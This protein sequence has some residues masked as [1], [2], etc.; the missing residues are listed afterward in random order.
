VRSVE[1][2][3]SR[4]AMDVESF[5]IKQA[6]LFVGKGYIHDLADI[7]HLPWD[8]IRTL[9]GYGEKRVENLLAGIEGSKQQPVH[10]LLTALGI[11][12]V[13]SVVAELLT[14][15]Y[16]NLFELMDASQEDLNAIEGV[17]PRIAESVHEWFQLGPNRE[18]IA[19]FAAAGVRVA[20]ERRKPLP[21]ALPLAGKTFV[22]T[23]TLPTLSREEA[24]ALIKAHGGKVAGS[25]S[26]KTSYVVVGEAAGSK[27]AKAQE[28]GIPTISEEELRALVE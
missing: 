9:E 15:R 17:G 7:Y 25:V 10:R 14:D 18:L 11:R 12:F 28:L 23:G 21:A 24:Q 16:P 3:V 13:G 1:Y 2:F 4:G 22:V 5:G 19:K 8:E 20:E 27:L 6:E 26:S